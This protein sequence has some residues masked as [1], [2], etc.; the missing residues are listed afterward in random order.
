MIK[1]LVLAGWRGISN[2]EVELLVHDRFS[3]HHFL[4][5][6]EM[7]P[8]RLTVWM[9]L[10]RLIEDGKAHLIWDELQRKL[11]E[12]GYSIKNGVI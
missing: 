4:M 8:D 10:E 1:M 12:K 9:F 11:G 7:I 3:F 2:Y 5:Y 6:P